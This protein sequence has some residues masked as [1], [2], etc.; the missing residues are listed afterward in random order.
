MMI[1]VKEGLLYIVTVR[2]MNT[3]ILQVPVTGVHLVLKVYVSP[4]PP[5]VLL[6]VAILW[7]TLLISQML[8]TTCNPLVMC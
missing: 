5:D 4:I 8:S 3:H 1:C 6:L 2:T 7:H